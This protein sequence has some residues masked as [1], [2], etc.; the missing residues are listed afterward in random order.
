M[1]QVGYI[2]NVTPEGILSMRPDM[3]IATETLG[4]PAAKKM[5]KQMGANVV[6]IPE[7]NSPEALEKGLRE[8]GETLGKSAKAEEIIVEVRAKLAETAD[9]AKR[10]SNRPTAVFF[11]SPPSSSGGG[12]AGGDD[13]RS[14]ELISL[15]GGENAVDFQGF[16]VMSIES[17]IKTDPDVIFV[18]VSDGHGASPE[19][20]EAMR[21]LPGLAG[22][23]AV[24][25]NAIYSVPLDDLSFGPRL[26]DAVQRW[27][28]HLAEAA[29]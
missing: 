13:T 21:H 18:G 22:T 3:I 8:V 27:N 16:Q 17:L 24:K 6:W 11:L 28:A 10:W 14:A 5:L 12:Q 26:G 1:P 4:P 9:V 19:S 29:K 25:N 20:V 15:A 7:P 23:K 2:R